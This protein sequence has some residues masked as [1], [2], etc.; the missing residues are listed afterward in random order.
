MHGQ[1]GDSAVS[2][3]AVKTGV[4]ND[5]RFETLVTSIHEFGA[6]HDA[7]TCTDRSCGHPDHGNSTRHDNFETRE[8]AGERYDGQQMHVERMRYARDLSVN[9][10]IAKGGKGALDAIDHDPEKCDISD[11]RLCNRITEASLQREVKV[12]TGGGGGNRG[13]KGK[14]GTA[15]CK[16]EGCGLTLCEHVRGSRGGKKRGPRP[17]ST[18]RVKTVAFKVTKAAGNALKNAGIDGELINKLGTAVQHGLTYAD[19]DAFIESKKQHAA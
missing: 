8:R 1:P 14:A 10:T 4:P 6:R 19:V 15:V 3:D 12:Q 18:S 11:C 5:E 13:P 16:V 2:A 9:E 17:K 7:A